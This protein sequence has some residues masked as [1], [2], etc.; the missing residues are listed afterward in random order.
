MSV[1]L[2]QAWKD[3]ARLEDW[4]NLREGA[5]VPE[6]P[7]PSTDDEFEGPAQIQEPEEPA[8]EWR[9]HERDWAGAEGIW[10]LVLG[11]PF[12]PAANLPIVQTS[13]V[14]APLRASHTYVAC[15]HQPL[16]PQLN[17]LRAPRS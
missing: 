9:K 15:T 1:D 16:S 3:V 5:W 14:L 13:C 11:K 17:L 8:E 2:Y 4:D 12:L 10:R 7:K 6:P